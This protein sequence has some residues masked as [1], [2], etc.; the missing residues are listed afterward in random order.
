MIEA[1]FS[2][3]EIDSMRETLLAN[4]GGTPIDS[5][6]AEEHLRALED[7]WMDSLTST[8]AVTDTCMFAVAQ[9]APVQVLIC[10]RR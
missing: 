6:D 8:E 4:A 1:G 2:Q 5:T 7:Q 10:A 9:A 3:E